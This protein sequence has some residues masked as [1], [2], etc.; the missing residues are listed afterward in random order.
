MQR[1]LK[2][3]GIEFQT[4]SA[5][6]DDQTANKRCLVQLQRETPTGFVDDTCGNE[7]EQGMAGLCR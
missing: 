7:V 1:L 2:D 6:A 5:V 4:E 3:N